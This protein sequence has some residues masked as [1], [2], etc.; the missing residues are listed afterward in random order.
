M[1]YDP[2]RKAD[3]NKLTAIMQV[4]NEADRYLETTLENLSSFVDEI[5]V[6]DDASTDQSVMLCKK[7]P[8]VRHMVELKTSL[9]H[10]EWKLRKIL[11]EAAV[12]T[13]PDWLLS[14]DADELYETK[15]QNEIHRLIN[16]EDYDW[17][18]FRLFDFW[19]CMTHYREDEHWNIHKRHTMTA[20]RYMPCYHYFYPEWNHHVPRL[21]STCGLLPGLRTE[22]RVKH[23]GWA[24]SEEERYRKYAR[25]MKNDPEAKWGSLAHYE[26]ILDPYPNLVEWKEDGEG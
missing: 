25:Y 6:V 14:V 8:K 10:Q 2:L 4:H 17:L 26:S 12:S 5:V 18:G 7:Y 19:G 3:N 9:F 23:L 22:L 21:P 24:C 16:Q 15:A 1:K 20:V 13:E 11:W